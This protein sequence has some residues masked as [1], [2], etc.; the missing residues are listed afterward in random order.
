MELTSQELFLERWHDLLH[1]G[2]T[3]GH[4][5]AFYDTDA[6]I[7]RL[8]MEWLIDRDRWE[9]WRDDWGA[10]RQPW[11]PEGYRYWFELFHDATGLGC[12]V[13]YPLGAAEGDPIKVR[14]TGSIRNRER[15]IPW[16]HGQDGLVEDRLRE[17]LQEMVVLHEAQRL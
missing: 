6:F 2:S 16:V 1:E 4:W 9:D 5:R 7:P 17:V 15:L 8:A 3:D 13:H 11:A 14:I 12:T 10:F